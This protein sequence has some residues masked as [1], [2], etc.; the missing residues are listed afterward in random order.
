MMNIFTHD[1]E[2]VLFYVTSFMICTAGGVGHLQ[3]QAP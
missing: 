2:G 1:W 3:I